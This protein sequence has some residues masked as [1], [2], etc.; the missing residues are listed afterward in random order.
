[1]RRKRVAMMGDFLIQNLELDGLP[2][3]TTTNGEALDL[4]GL[5]AS[6]S[7]QVS[8]GGTLS[9]TTKVQESND[10]TTW[11][12]I[13][14]ASVANSGHTFGTALAA[15]ARYTRLVWTYTSGSG[16]LLARFYVR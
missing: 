6:L 4:R 3:E 13:T 2:A 16:N 1:M 11:V 12:D 8:A 14:S 15:K 5:G 10:K 9:G 7:L